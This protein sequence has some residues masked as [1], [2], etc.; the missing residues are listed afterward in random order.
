LEYVLGDPDTGGAAESIHLKPD[1]AEAIIAHRHRHGIPIPGSS[2]RAGWKG[3]PLFVIRLEAGASDDGGRHL[4]TR[5]AVD[6]IRS[7][8]GCPT[9][10]AAGLAQLDGGRLVGIAAVYL[11]VRKSFIA[12]RCGRRAQRRQPPTRRYR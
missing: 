7:F 4:A 9:V 10:G 5:T 3:L 11:A 12:L 8:H 6:V 2:L 1:L